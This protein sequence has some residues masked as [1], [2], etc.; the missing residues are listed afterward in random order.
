MDTMGMDIVGMDI[1]GTDDTADFGQ[2]ILRPG[3]KRAVPQLHI[4]ALRGASAQGISMP[5]EELDFCPFTVTQIVTGGPTASS[6]VSFP[7]R[8]FRG[9]RLIA[10]AVL[11]T[12]GGSIDAGG[13]VQIDPAIYVGGVQVGATQGGTPLS[14]FAPTAFGVRLSFPPAGQGTRIFIPFVYVGPAFGAGDTLFVSMTVIG[15]A[16]R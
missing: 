3:S 14:T 4:P 9:E 2:L 16:V 8:P 11:T 1:I 5:Q 15:R 10:S 7:Q 12:A 13:L 6:G